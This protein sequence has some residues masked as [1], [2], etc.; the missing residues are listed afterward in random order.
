M[1]DTSPKDFSTDPN[2]NTTVWSVSIAEGA[3][4]SD[5]NNSQRGILAVI[6]DADWGAGPIKSDT[7]AESTADAGV[8]IDG[9]TIKD[10]DFDTLPASVTALIPPGVVWEFAGA[11]APT[12]W[13]ICDG[14]AVSRTTYGA[15]FTAI[16]TTYGAGDGTTTF[17]LPDRRGRTAIGVG[18]G[19][20]SDATAHALG[21]EGGAETH[22]LTKAQLPNERLLTIVNSNTSTSG[23]TS[24][25]T[26][27]V[28]Q[29]NSGG[30]FSYELNSSS[31][32]PTHGRTSPM[33]DGT[34][35]NI[36]QPFIVMNFMI[37]T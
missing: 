10:G 26:S 13:L 16:G 35:H 29:N 31:A 11:S 7:I 17:N 21:E 3:S 19:D 18:T 5:M 34:A 37:K 28:R 25:T 20:A 36:M 23:S 27:P 24:G 2:V 8:T 9:L 4:T 12:G 33:G 6:K 30:Q 32:E 22:T 15:L 1:P 14:S